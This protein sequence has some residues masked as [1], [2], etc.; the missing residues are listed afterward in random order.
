[1]MCRNAR[2]GEYPNLLPRDVVRGGTVTLWRNHANRVFGE[3]DAVVISNRWKTPAEIPAA[4]RSSRDEEARLAATRKFAWNASFGYL[5]PDPSHCGIGLGIEGEFH[6]EGLHLIGDLPPVLAGLEAVRFSS[7]SLNTDGIRQAA[8]LFRISNNA[9]LGILE[10]DLIARTERIFG[11]LV[12]QELAARKAL[13][14]DNP[15]VFADSVA[16]ALAILGSARLLAP[17]ELFDLL[18]PVLLA[19]SMGFL[20]GITRTEILKMMN[21]QLDKPELPPSETPDDERVRDDRDS[22]L[23]DRINRRFATVAFNHRAEDY[24][25]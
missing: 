25:S 2:P 1:M 17:G 9:T 6:L 21:A 8:H 7:R 5:S 11:D 22:R 13:V 23:A 19:A 15:R 12:T 18:S 3:R 14:R 10:D 4:Y 16:R 24:L 20:D